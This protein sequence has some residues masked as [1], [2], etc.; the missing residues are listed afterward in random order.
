MSLEV[1]VRRIQPATGV[2]GN[3]DLGVG[4]EGSIGTVR[5]PV[6]WIGKVDPAQSVLDKIKAKQTDGNRV[7]RIKGTIMTCWTWTATMGLPLSQPQKQ[8]SRSSSP[9]LWDGQPGRT[10]K[11]CRRQSGSGSPNFG[12]VPPLRQPPLSVIRHKGRQRQTIKCRD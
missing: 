10:P 3:G 1:Q 8:D 5:G 2:M 6:T 7:V 4:D 12:R 11:A 9:K